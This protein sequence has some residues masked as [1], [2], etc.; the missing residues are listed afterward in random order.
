MPLQIYKKKCIYTYFRSFFIKQLTVSLP[1]NDSSL[2]PL[3]KNFD[4]LAIKAKYEF[5]KKANDKYR[6][7]AGN[8]KRRANLPIRPPKLKVNNKTELNKSQKIAYGS[9]VKIRSSRIKESIGYLNESL[10]SKDLNLSSD[11]ASFNESMGTESSTLVPLKEGPIEKPK[12]SNL[13]KEVSVTTDSS[14]VSTPGDAF[15]YYLDVKALKHI[16]CSVLQ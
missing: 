12:E 14:K 10:A 1:V 13:E 16:N 4:K 7:L 9:V 5:K 8:L 2:N 11:S 3:R 15:I 6:I